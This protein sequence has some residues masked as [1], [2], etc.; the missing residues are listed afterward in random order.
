M[1]NMRKQTSCSRSRDRRAVTWRRVRPRVQDG[2]PSHG[3]VKCN[4]IRDQRIV[5]RRLY[6]SS[7]GN[8]RTE[9]HLDVPRT[10][11]CLSSARSTLHSQHN[12]IFSTLDPKP[13]PILYPPRP[14]T[15]PHP[16]TRTPSR[17][18]NRP[19][20]PP[21]PPH[22]R[23]THRPRDQRTN[24]NHTKRH[25][26][27]RSRLTDITTQSGY[28]CRKQTLKGRGEKAVQSDEGVVAGDGR[29]TEPGPEHGGGK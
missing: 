3:M 5:T 7:Y 2:R 25:A 19:R 27:P 15:H 23:T 10:F 20:I 4:C 16:D 26:Q 12:A 6:A 13:P 8:I 1:H 18:T 11:P 24:P 14:N 9:S 28:C 17:P 21:T 29:Y 22:H